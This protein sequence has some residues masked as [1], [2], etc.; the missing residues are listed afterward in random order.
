[1]KS[2]PPSVRFRRDI[3]GDRL[4]AW[5]T[6]IARLYSIQLTSQG[7]D[8]FRC[9]LIANSKFTITLTQP[10]QPVANIKKFWLIKISLKTKIFAWYLHRGVIH[11]KDSL[12]KSN[13][14]GSKKCPFCH[15]NETIKHLF[16]QYYFA[17]FIWSNMQIASSL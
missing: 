9:N 2:S 10:L 8:E 7:A 16:F 3:V 12:A 17:S 5:N 14:Q 4:A 1:M 13:W 15:H 6:L 11:T